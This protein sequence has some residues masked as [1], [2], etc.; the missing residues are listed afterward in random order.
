MR[1]SDVRGAH[2]SRGFLL[3][4]RRLE[5]VQEAG[6][7]AAG[8]AVEPVAHQRHRALAHGCLALPQPVPDQARPL[9][10]AA[11]MP[12]SLVRCPSACDG[13]PPQGDPERCIPLSYTRSVAARALEGGPRDEG[14]MSTKAWGFDEEGG[15]EA[16]LRN[17]KGTL[18]LM[19]AYAIFL[20]CT[21]S[22]LSSL[23]VNLHKY[24]Q[25]TKAIEAAHDLAVSA[26]SSG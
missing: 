19:E 5:Q 6:N 11:R 4:A 7:A 26:V 14:A 12:H 9:L 25:F 3:G 2:H 23:D 17:S 13:S 24:Q 22:P 1:C 15:G 8:I 16:N 10:Q 18:S 21:P 20:T